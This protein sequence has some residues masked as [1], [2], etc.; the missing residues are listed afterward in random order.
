[1]K[2]RELQRDRVVQLPARLTRNRWMP[3]SREFEHHQI[4]PIDLN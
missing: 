3:I 4:W 1:M 2:Q